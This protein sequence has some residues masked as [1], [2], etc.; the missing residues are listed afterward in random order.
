MKT[1]TIPAAADDQIQE[2]PLEVFK[3]LLGGT[4]PACKHLNL[5]R[6][7]SSGK[8]LALVHK[9]DSEDVLRA[10]MMHRAQAAGRAKNE[11]TPAEIRGVWKTAKPID[12]KWFCRFVKASPEDQAVLLGEV[13]SVRG[14]GPLWRAIRDE[15]HATEIEDRVKQDRDFERVLAYLFKTEPPANRAAEHPYVLRKLRHPATGETIPPYGAIWYPEVES[16]LKIGTYN[17]AYRFG[18]EPYSCQHISADGDKRPTTGA[19]KKWSFIVVE[20]ENLLIES[21]V[22]VCEGWATACT[23]AHLLGVRAVVAFDCGQLPRVAYLVAHGECGFTPER[24]LIVADGVVAGET[25]PLKKAQQ[26]AQVTMESTVANADDAIPA[27]VVSPKHP[28]GQEHDNFDFNDLWHLD[29]EEAKRQL[30]EAARELMWIPRAAVAEALTELDIGAVV[31]EINR[32]FAFVRDLN[33]VID[34][35]AP[36]LKILKKQ[37]FFDWF[38][39]KPYWM[40]DVRGGRKPCNRGQLWFRNRKRREYLDLEFTPGER[41]NPENLNLWRGFA[42]KPKSGDCGFFWELTFESICAGNDTFFDYSR[43]YLA[44]GV[45]KPWELPGVAVVLR[46]G[47]GIG[48]N[49]YVDHYGRLFGPH[50]TTLSDMGRLLGRFN[51]ALAGKVVI[52][53]VE[54]VWGGDRAAEGKLK[55]LITDGRQMIERKGREPVEISNFAR[56]FLSS[57]E[58]WCAPVGLDDRRYLILDAKDTYRNNHQFFDQLYKQMAAGGVAALLHELM[59]V[60]LTDFNIRKL[61]DG[62]SAWDLKVRSADSPIRWW[63]DT[64]VQGTIPGGETEGTS[65]EEMEI[66]PATVQKTAV[67]EV[68]HNWCKQHG[69]RHPASTETL[70]RALKAMMSTLGVIQPRIDGGRKRLYKLPPLD[71]CRADFAAHIGA[72]IPWDTL[73]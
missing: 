67:Q 41:G 26:A 59:E 57:N 55:S 22:A 42:V 23:V 7:C 1:T 9:L 44:H 52:H 40:T 73:E 70:G 53:L 25:D 15:L 12:L 8:K 60:D 50:F 16:R 27:L 14:D 5:L 69:I 37:E 32:Q 61:P 64:L 72:E 71:L 39:N 66:W 33:G 30:A 28:D 54:A 34:L 24:V 45:Q 62:A 11:T 20:P 48:K 10:I 6:I 68:Y 21:V 63:F 29:P 19:S 4:D 38:E 36:D 13:E 2:T 35:S 31:D 43:K 3:R 46:G 49:S 51:S 17:A 56:L 65:A 18:L 47:Q 58:Q